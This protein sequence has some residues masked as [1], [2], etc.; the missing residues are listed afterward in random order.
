MLGHGAFGRD[1]GHGSDQACEQFRTAI[2]RAAVGG[3]YDVAD[4]QIKILALVDPSDAILLA[5]GNKA[6]AAQRNGGVLA[7]CLLA[8]PRRSITHK[9]VLLQTD[10]GLVAVDNASLVTKAGEPELGMGG[11]TAAAR[12]D[13]GF[14]RTFSIGGG[15]LWQYQQIRF[16][17]GSCIGGRTYVLFY[18]FARPVQYSSLCPYRCIVFCFYCSA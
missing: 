15:V 17:S 1:R 5:L 9:A 16:G 18:G 10:D 4:E 6:D 8:A 14:L 12:C 7:K 13:D 3:K 11:L 2:H